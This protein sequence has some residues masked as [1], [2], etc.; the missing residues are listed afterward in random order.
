MGNP[1]HFFAKYGIYES[2]TLMGVNILNI[3][4]DLSQWTQ[5]V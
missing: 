5:T 4:V 1:L 2:T 3:G